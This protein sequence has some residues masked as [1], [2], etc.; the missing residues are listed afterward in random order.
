MTKHG[1]LVEQIP[2][3]TERI[4]ELEGDKRRIAEEMQVLKKELEVASQRN[5]R[6][7][8]DVEMLVAERVEKEIQANVSCAAVADIRS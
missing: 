4:A 6:L 1:K 3:A 2:T 5:E 8:R 7:E